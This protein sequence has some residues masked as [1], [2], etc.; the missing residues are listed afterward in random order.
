[1]RDDNPEAWAE[2]VAVDRAIRT[3]VRGIRGEI[4]LHRSAL[5]LDEVDLTTPADVGQLDLWANE[6]E[7]LCGV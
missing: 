5:P 4:F 6:C 7:G 3:G 2:A 1:M